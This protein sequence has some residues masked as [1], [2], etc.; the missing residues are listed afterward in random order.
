MQ[1]GNLQITNIFLF[2]ITHS[3]LLIKSTRTISWALMNTEKLP[4][5]T[6]SIFSLSSTEQKHLSTSLPYRS[7]TSVRAETHLSNPPTHNTASIR[8]HFF[9]S[10]HNVE[11]KIYKIFMQFEI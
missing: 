3:L 10:C 8:G 11:L 2:G 6:A 4:K 9:S 7:G 1:A 5:T